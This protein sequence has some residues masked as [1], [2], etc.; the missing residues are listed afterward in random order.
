MQ[1]IYIL[2]SG[3][4]GYLWASYF[5]AAAKIHLITRNQTD[6]TFKFEKHPNLQTIHAVKTHPAQ[7]S[8]QNTNIHFLIV[9]TKAFDAEKAL[10]SIESNL[11]KDCQIILIQNGLGS[12]QAIAKRYP[13]LSIYACSSTEGVFKESDHL[14]IHAGQGENHIGALTPT[15]KQSTLS[16]WLPTSTFKWHEDIAPILWRK[17]VINSAINPLTVIYQCQNGALLSNPTAHAHM[18]SLC[19]ELDALCAQLN[20]NLTPTIHLAE[21]ICQST[22]NNYS[23]MYQDHKHQRPTEIHYITGYVIEACKKRG[24]ECPVHE[25]VAEQIVN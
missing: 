8:Q 18:K 23:S 17:L 15:A 4:M 5:N 1:D 16:S 19:L 7:L 9:C 20:L 12:Q 6:E 11:A 25:H 13:T 14:L 10:I 2:G 3:A 22:A 21:S 24:I